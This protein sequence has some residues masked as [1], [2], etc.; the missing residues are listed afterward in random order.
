MIYRNPK[1]LRL[2]RMVCCAKCGAPYPE[3]AHSDDHK[4]GKC[5]GVKNPDWCHAALCRSCH[6]GYHKTHDHEA[7]ERHILSTH[8]AYISEGLVDGPK[9]ETLEEL[10]QLWE[11][12]Q[13]RV[14]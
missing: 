14:R 7:F 13:L 6:E 8:R 2:A 3:A 1:L 5:L 4:Y 10:Q 11:S 9:F 12:K